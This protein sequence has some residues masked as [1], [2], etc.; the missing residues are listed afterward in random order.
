M[1]VNPGNVLPGNLLTS[2]LTFFVIFR[3]LFIIFV[4]TLDI[5]SLRVIAYEREGSKA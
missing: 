5:I 4:W 2:D 3:N 1:C